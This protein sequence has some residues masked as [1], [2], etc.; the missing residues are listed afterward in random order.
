MF[1]YGNG[2]SSWGYTLMTVSMVLFWGL[3]IFGVVA[4]IRYLTRAPQRSAGAEAPRPAPE[5]ILAERFARGE[6]DEQEYRS[7]LATLSGSPNS[8]S[9]T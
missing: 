2:M 3:V 9:G 4:L 8:A 6:I 1:W 5:Q 7:R